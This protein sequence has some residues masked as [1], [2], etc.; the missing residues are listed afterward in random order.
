M[1]IEKKVFLLTGSNIEP[2]A[3]FL[4]LANKK[5]EENIGKI[6]GRSS[7]YES[8]PWGFEA[9]TAFLNQ[10]LVVITELAPN[11]ILEKIQS[12]E[13]E[14]GR[15]RKSNA[16]VSRTI[17]I[18]ILY[19]ES[20]IIESA[21][22]TV[23]HPRLHERRFTLLPLAEIAGGFMHPVLKKTNDELLQKVED[24]SRVWKVEVNKSWEN[25]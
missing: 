8:E 9:E 13:K 5:I 20:E 2:R 19:F 14:L 24:Q 18:D 23:P 12:T 11:E 16:Y 22:L 1:Q 6:V 7:I 4:A 3:K 21:E 17:D 10:V 15:F 25:V